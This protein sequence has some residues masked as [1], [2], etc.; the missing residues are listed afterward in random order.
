MPD[1]YRRDDPRQMAREMRA[2]SLMSFQAGCGFRDRGA[3]GVS[4]RKNRQ[5]TI[6]RPTMM[7]RVILIHMVIVLIAIIL[8]KNNENNS[9][10]VINDSNYY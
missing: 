4:I 8:I 1:I 10:I 5:T 3:G 9:N 6:A 2:E 7:I